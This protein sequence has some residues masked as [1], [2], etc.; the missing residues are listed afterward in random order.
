MGVVECAVGIVNRLKYYLFKRK[1]LLYF[2][3]FI[4][5]AFIL[6]NEKIHFLVGGVFIN[7]GY[8]FQDHVDQQVHLASPA[9]L[10]EH[11]QEIFRRNKN[12]SLVRSF[13]PRSVMHP[14]VA[15]LTCMDARIDTVEL[16]ADTRRSYYTLR[17]AGSVL[18]PLQQE[19]FELAVMNGVRVIVL[20]THSDCSAEKMAKSNQER[21]FPHLSRGVNNRQKNIDIFIHRPRIYEKIM[22]GE[23]IVVE[24]EIHTL[25]GS[26]TLIKI[27]DQKNILVKSH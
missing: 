26:M 4:F 1:F 19:M 14:Q 15:L 20:T 10:S 11:L 9:D 8:R 22:N 18:E 6:F 24:A 5:S 3:I 17:T 12:A 2:F 23:L 25:D 27:H 16:M 13:F 7:M 21:H